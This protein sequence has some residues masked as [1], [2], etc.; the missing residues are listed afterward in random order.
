MPFQFGLAEQ[1]LTM[2][3][4]P[5][6][7]DGV[8]ADSHRLPYRPYLAGRP[9]IDDPATVPEGAHKVNRSGPRILARLSPFPLLSLRVPSLWAKM[10]TLVALRTPSEG[11]YFSSG[12][13]P[14]LLS[15]SRPSLTWRGEW[16]PS[17]FDLMDQPGR[18][19]QL[20]AR[21]L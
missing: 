12:F 10:W 11:S 9:D 14:R 8:S 7:R 3:F 18:F 20:Q 19:R 13:V 6:H 5:D 2:G 15:G 4:V 17:Q 21:R 16:W 1:W